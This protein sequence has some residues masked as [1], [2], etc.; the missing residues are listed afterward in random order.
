[1]SVSPCK[2]VIDR[3]CLSKGQFYESLSPI[4]T[5]LLAKLEIPLSAM[6]ALEIEMELWIWTSWSGW[7]RTTRYCPSAL[8][9]VDDR[10]QWTFL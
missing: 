10:L 2:E 8:M 5:Y 7:H 9:I 1:M 6:R 3:Q 4:R